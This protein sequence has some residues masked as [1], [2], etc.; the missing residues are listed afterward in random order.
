[1]V[2]RWYRNAVIYSVDVGLFQDTDDD[3][4]GDFAGMVRRLDYLSRLG[5]TT[6]WL[7]PIHPSPKRDGGY[8]VTD[9][10]GVHARYGSFGDFCQFLNGAG[11]RGIRVM[12]DFVVNHTSDEHPWFRSARADRDSLYRDWYV[13]SDTEPPDRFEGQVFPGVESEVWTYDEQAG[14]WYRHR[15]YSFEPDLNTENPEVR[16]EIKKIAE[17]W[18]RVGVSGYR[19]DAAPFVIEPKAPGSIGKGDLD[20]A[21]YRELRERV[22]WLRG[23]AALLAEANVPDDEVL[24]YFGH[25]DGSASRIQL[26]FAFRLNQAIMLALA[27]EDARPIIATVRELPDL[28]RYGQWATFLRNHDEVDLGRLTPEERQEVF[29]AFGPDPDMQLYDRGIRR[30]LAPMLGGDRRRIELAY[31]LQF[32]MPGTPV[33]RYGDEIGMGENLELRERE[34]IRTPMQWDDTVNAGFSR[35]DPATL[36]VPVISA[37]PYGYQQVNVTDERR[38]VNSLLV[39]FERTLHSLRECEEIG[40]GNHTMLDVDPPHVLVH[41]ATGEAGAMLFLHNLADVPCRVEVGLQADRPGRP[42]SVVADDDY[43]E[44]VDLGAVDLNGYGYRWIRLRHNP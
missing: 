3:G 13:W 36:P 8:D 5:V 41:R 14:A 15:F 16:E 9:H 42:L 11:E 39:W 43:P 27:R 40:S 35:A 44:E 12:L 28:P 38:D 10:Y 4:V 26:I 37:G 33:I 2:E 32:T 1:M 20:Y 17:A 34:A 31:S 18:L 29:E 7:N 6:I 24:E 21:F 22:S 23:D 30:R 19:I 25:A